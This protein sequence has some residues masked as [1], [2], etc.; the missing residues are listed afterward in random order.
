MKETFCPIPWNHIGIHQN[1]RFKI[2]CQCIHPPFGHLTDD[3]KLV[4]IQ[5]HTIDQA[6][7]SREIKQLRQNMLNGIK[8]PLC[9]LCWDEESAGLNSKRNFINTVYPKIYDLAVEKTQQDGSIDT[10][11]FP[12]RY[13]DFRFG[14]L[15]NLKCRYCGPM[16][17]SL[18]YSDYYKIHKEIFG[19]YDD[20]SNSYSIV[21]N[22]NS[23]GIDSTD[24]EWHLD[25]KFW[26]NI[27]EILPF[28]DRFYFT[29]GEPMIN[30]SHIKMLEL[31]IEMNLA[32]NIAIEYNSNMVAIPDK[33]YDLW[34]EFS[35]VHIG[36][37]IDAIGNLANYLRFPTDWEK[38]EKNLD[39]LGYCDLPNL[40]AAIS[41]TIS[42]FNIYHFLDII[43]WL[44]NKNYSK[45]YKLPHFHM[46][47]GPASMNVQIL[48]EDIKSDIEDKYNTF[49]SVNTDIK[50]QELYGSIL[51]FMKSKNMDVT[52]LQQL[53][54]HTH[55]LDNLRGHTL[56]FELPWLND[57]LNSTT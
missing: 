40:S 46:L 2:C 18:W 27:K 11:E 26:E 20:K 28:V 22:G 6:R 17:S 34:K 23:W 51:T 53:K 47:M 32:K 5:T 43:T 36:C 49:A 31:C 14:N 16:D 21:Q 54:D 45:I 4:K 29:G 52:L 48:P 3:D 1:G 38:V 56:E 57:V 10:T 41:T 7:N 55:K 44:Q 39:K 37:S 8:D 24:F 19:S 12:V 33:M 13:F 25:D 15:C 30:K 50:F 35:S 9:K 42:I